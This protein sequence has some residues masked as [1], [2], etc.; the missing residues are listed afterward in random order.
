MAQF[1]RV[2]RVIIQAAY[3][4]TVQKSEKGTKQLGSPKP[5]CWELPANCCVWL[6]AVILDRRSETRDRIR[7]A[8]R[9]PSV[10]GS[11]FSV[12][13]AGA[14]W[15]MCCGCA[16]LILA[17]CGEAAPSETFNAFN[18][19][20]A[21]RAIGWYMLMSA[22][23]EPTCPGLYCAAVTALTFPH[24]VAVLWWHL[25]VH[26]YFCSAVTALACP[27]FYVSA[28]TAHS[29]ECWIVLSITWKVDEH[30]LQ[31]HEYAICLRDPYV[32]P[33]SGNVWNFRLLWEKC[34]CTMRGK[35]VKGLKSVLD[36]NSMHLNTMYCWSILLKRKY[37]PHAAKQTV[38]HFLLYDSLCLGHHQWT[39]SYEFKKIGVVQKYRSKG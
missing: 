38:N 3:R 6:H 9:W 19:F 1:R 20:L 25:H 33:S 26:V 7:P 30:G 4:G 16:T 13:C 24:F 12:C 17:G 5:V 23:T 22:V 31:L 27:H 34:P 15:C 28:V 32:P 29:Y 37:G 10:W 36:P 2:R 11:S 39:N 8:F 18:R 14:S 21:D 35:H